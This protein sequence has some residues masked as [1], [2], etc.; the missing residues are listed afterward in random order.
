MVGV[1]GEYEGIIDIDEDVCC[2]ERIVAVEETVVERGHR[3]PFCAEGGAI[4]LVKY[5]T[6]VREAV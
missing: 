5:T 6:G 3:V 1:V 2:F 4:V